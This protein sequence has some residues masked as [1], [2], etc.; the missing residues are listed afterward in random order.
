MEQLHLGI[1]SREELST[2]IG[3]DN[4]NKNFARKVKDTLTNWGYSF[5]YSCR[6]TK[7]TKVPVTAEERLAEIMYREFEIDTRVDTYAFACFVNLLLTYEDFT[8]MPW[9]QRAIELKEI[10]GVDVAEITLKRW[11]SKLIKENVLSKSK[12][13][14]V[15]WQTY[16]DTCGNTT[17]KPVFG[18]ELE[19]E[20]SS[21]NQRR[22][23]LVEQFTKDGSLNPWG[24]TFKQLWKEFGCCYYGCSKM[25][26]N[27]IGKTADEIFCFVAEIS[28]KEPF[29]TVIKTEISLTKVPVG[30]QF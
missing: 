5:E 21:Y 22:N 25:V 30:F 2:I 13:D 19:A 12:S 4:S 1:Y 24:E 28:E 18:E 6:Q 7:I 27:A 10:Y 8:F 11:A 23:T 29:E 16:K 15:Y 26:L 3:V 17:R 14:K 9:G 20:L